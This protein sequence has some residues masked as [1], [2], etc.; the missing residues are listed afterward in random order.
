[1]T[2]IVQDTYPTFERGTTGKY[3]FNYYFYSAS[4]VAVKVAPEDIQSYYITLP[5]VGYYTVERINLNGGTVTITNMTAAD[6]YMRSQLAIKYP[7]SDWTDVQFQYVQTPRA[8]P[9]EQPKAQSFSYS[10]ARVENADD[11]LCLLEQQTAEKLEIVWENDAIW[12]INDNSLTKDFLPKSYATN[13]MRLIDST[14]KCTTGSPTTI[15]DNA[16]ITGYLQVIGDL[17]VSGASSLQSVTATTITTSSNVSVGGTLYVDAA[18]TLNSTLTVAGNA[19]LGGTLSVAGATALNGTLTVAGNA[20]F[21]SPVDFKSNVAIDGNTVA[22]AI[23]CTTLTATGTVNVGGALFCSSTSE[24]VGAATF[25]STVDVYGTLWARTS[26]NVA[27]N[28]ILYGNVEIKGTTTAQAINATSVIAPQIT[29]TDNLTFG[30]TFIMDGQTFRMGQISETI[31]NFYLFKV[32]SQSDGSWVIYMAPDANDGTGEPPENAPP[33]N[34]FA[35]GDGMGDV[36]ASRMDQNDNLEHI[37]TPYDFIAN[38][39]KA[40]NDLFVMRNFVLDGGMYSTLSLEGTYVK[41][42]FLKVIE[43]TEG[44]RQLVWAEGGGGAIVDTE[45]DRFPIGDGEQGLKDSMLAQD[46]VNGYIYTGYGLSSRDIKLT[47][48]IAQG[49]TIIGSMNTQTMDWRVFFDFKGIDQLNQ[50]DIAPLYAKYYGGNTISIIA[51]TELSPDLF[52]T[53]P[54]IDHA[55][56]V[57]N[58]H[59]SEFENKYINNVTPPSLQDYV[60]SNATFTDEL[61]IT[62]HANLMYP[63]GLSSNMIYLDVDKATEFYGDYATSCNITLIGDMVDGHEIVIALRRVN[64]GGLINWPTEWRWSMKFAPISSNFPIMQYVIILLQR[65]GS[66]YYA[67]RINSQALQEPDTSKVVVLGEHRDNAPL[68]FF[69]TQ[70]YKLEVVNQ[71][72]I[73]GNVLNGLVLNTLCIVKSSYSDTRVVV[74]ANNVLDIVLGAETEFIVKVQHDED[75]AAVNITFDADEIPTNAVIRFSIVMMKGL[76]IQK[77]IPMPNGV[78]APA[79]IEEN[80]LLLGD[81]NNTIFQFVAI[82]GNGLYYIGGIAQ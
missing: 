70:G 62:S 30:K 36:K 5:N 49:S 72:T 81:Y 32:A 34:N 19:T 9:Y 80:E 33:F 12:E 67:K 55:L 2:Q 75:I 58:G 63:F 14:I 18:T 64:S 43:N 69:D 4:D 17:T 54:A 59:D 53:E 7:D 41:D 46:S 82:P 10:A 73:Y 38:N 78:K 71:G 51:G 11:W 28:S 21:N 24:F 79:V 23:V 15:N 29:S 1:M 31:Q 65:N 27:G 42:Y 50:G 44:N 52:L 22:H 37:I 74:I 47:S 3:E 76:S 13:T 6:E 39:I 16:L 61:L 26:F 56:A 40:E 20:T 77:A 8:L 45:L 68:N 60:M 48:N 66:V 35:I 57:W 25:R